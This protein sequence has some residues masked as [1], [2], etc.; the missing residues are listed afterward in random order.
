MRFTVRQLLK[1]A[2]GDSDNTAADTLLPRVGG[3]ACR[4]PDSGRQPRVAHRVRSYGLCST[5]LAVIPANAGIHLAL[6]R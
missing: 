5:L 3:P 2:V 1:A 4:A 6:G